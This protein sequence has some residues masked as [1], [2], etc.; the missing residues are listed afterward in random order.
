MR[1]MT[2]NIEAGGGEDRR[3]ARVLDV[4]REA[5]PDVLVVNECVGWFPSNERA[6]A[7]AACLGADYRVAQCVSNFDL[8]FFSRFPIRAIETPESTT[9]FTHG[10]ARATLDVDGRPMTVTGAHLDFRD[11]RTRA[12]EVG[13]ML[14][15]LGPPGDELAAIVGDLNAITTGDE[16]LGIE[17]DAVADI[18]DDECPEWLFQRYPPRAIARLQR[19][20]WV[21]AFRTR[22]PDD[23]GYTMSTDEPNARYDYVFLS[24]GAAR[25][26]RD[27]EVVTRAPAS[28]ASDHF[29]VVVDLELL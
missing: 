23:A 17:G 29:G 25:G 15:W 3:F 22:H 18:P 27:A 20:G 19:A 16:V 12:D 26:L 24:P 4:V 9:T 6:D 28:N 1:L 10:V 11:E 13:A 14:A 8:A 2:Y 21:D 7:I 5:S